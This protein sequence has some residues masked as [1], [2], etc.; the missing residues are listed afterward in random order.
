MA[1]S[2]QVCRSQLLLEMWITA[3]DMPW[4][5]RREMRGPRQGVAGVDV[6][7]KK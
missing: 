5:E 7:G 1:T 6:G 4:V 2:D 3:T